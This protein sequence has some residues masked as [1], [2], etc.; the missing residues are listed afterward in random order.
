MMGR[1]RFIRIEVDREVGWQWSCML[2]LVCPEKSSHHVVR[3]LREGSTV[4]P[5]S[6]HNIVVS[7]REGSCR[8]VDHFDACLLA[9]LLEARCGWGHQLRKNVR[10]LKTSATS[11]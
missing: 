9:L 3:R 11:T 4:I 5:T 8:V 10:T 7:P 2:T 6:R 1:H